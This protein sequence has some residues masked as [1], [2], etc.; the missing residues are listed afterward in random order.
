MQVQ[1]MR[2]KVII[3]NE[4]DRIFPTLES[5]D[6]YF[7]KRKQELHK[8]YKSNGIIILMMLVKEIK[9]DYWIGVK[10]N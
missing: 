9:P 7:M 8:K 3:E 1:E 2:S 6:K 5:G 10:R 4:K